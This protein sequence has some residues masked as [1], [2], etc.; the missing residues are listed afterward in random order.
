MNNQKDIK[1]DLVGQVSK[2]E[3]ENE[4]LILFFNK[5]NNRKEKYKQFQINIG[6]DI[7]KEIAKSYLNTAIDN[8]NRKEIV[9]YDFEIDNS[10]AIQ[11]INHKLIIDSEKINS[12]IIKDKSVPY[13]DRKTDFRKF[14]FIVIRYFLNI[15]KT[16][17]TFT[18]YSQYFQPATRFKK[19]FKY[20]F[21]DDEIKKLD[22]DIFYFDGRVDVFE[23]EK[24]YFIINLKWFNKIFDFKEGFNRIIESKRSEIVNQGFIDNPDIFIDDCKKD[25]RYNQRL[26][27]IVTSDAFESLEGQAHKLPEYFKRF[28]IS[29]TLDKNNII[30]YRGKEDIG[31]ILNILMRRYAIDGLTDEEMIITGIEEYIS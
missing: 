8:I 13:V 7:A 11:K 1:S 9:K 27:K 23:F 10:D 18:I 3:N 21:L 31:Q 14:N 17:K 28:K 15:D 5:G 12:K 19:S 6:G 20:C 24:K 2:F 22:S 29:L 25:G 26:C 4:P 30:Q 16:V